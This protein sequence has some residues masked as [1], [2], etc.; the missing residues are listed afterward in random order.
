MHSDPTGRNVIHHIG[1]GLLEISQ[2]RD[3]SYHQLSGGREES[4]DHTTWVPCAIQSTH[5]TCGYHTIYNGWAAALGLRL[6]PRF[7][8][9]WTPGFLDQAQNLICLAMLGQAS[10]EMIHNYL[11]CIDFV[12]PKQV[13][14]MSLRF[15]NTVKT[16]ETTDATDETTL[17]S[18]MD[19][20][21]QTQEAFWMSFNEG[22]ERDQAIKKISQENRVHFLK[23]NSR[24]HDADW[25]ADTWP[26]PIEEMNE[27]VKAHQRKIY[28]GDFD[29]GQLTYHAIMYANKSAQTMKDVCIG[30]RRYYQRVSAAGSR[31]GVRLFHDYI[32]IDSM[33]PSF[34]EEKPVNV[35]SQHFWYLDK[36]LQKKDTLQDT[37]QPSFFSLV[38]EASAA[39]VQA[40]DEKQQRQSGHLFTS[41]FT[42]AT[43][44][45]IQAA[46]SGELG[47]ATRPRRCWLMPF[48]F[49]KDQNP[50]VKHYFLAVLQEEKANTESGSEF[51]VY[52]FDS[53]PGGWTNDTETKR[54]QAFDQVKT[55]AHNLQ[56]TNHRN[57]GARVQFC[58]KPKYVQVTK[59]KGDDRSGYHTILNVWILS[60]GMTPKIK[61]I[62]EMD[63]IYPE[64]IRMTEIAIRGWLDWR[65]LV[66]W[67]FMCDLTVEK[68]IGPVTLERA[69]DVSA[70]QVTNVSL[71][72]YVNN[73]NP[74]DDL[75][76]TRIEEDAPYIHNNVDFS[77]DTWQ[78]EEEE[79]EQD[80]SEP[81]VLHR[82]L[83]DIDMLDRTGNEDDWS[84]FFTELTQTAYNDLRFN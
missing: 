28:V 57:I 49:P 7:F 78:F 79:H 81:H 55:I 20:M 58:T 29:L 42:L 71:R 14:D 82:A 47:I 30:F 38:V 6:N 63:G 33:E 39:I 31:S 13:V 52:F 76:G 12:L 9:V 61:P 17:H 59:Q 74:Q 41:G 73:T 35:G 37:R 21:L 40:I 34:I 16:D 43:R 62:F 36:L 2:W 8:K 22:E 5:Y 46:R 77:R 67:L 56:W 70:L 27:I 50:L 60:L 54:I 64:L 15:Q 80:A 45:A 75:L 23:G 66:A 72:G 26:K 4:L 83:E 84:S 32:Q 53:D 18:T 3:L 25:N 68:T 44:F 69:F 51:R 19:E 65:T 48:Q 1:S 11:E 10:S 24:R